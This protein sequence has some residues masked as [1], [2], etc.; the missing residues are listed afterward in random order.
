MT[1]ATL[2]ILIALVAA[3]SVAA[4]A[5]GASKAPSGPATKAEACV[6]GAQVMADQARRGAT[7]FDG[8]GAFPSDYFQTAARAEEWHLSETH[9]AFLAKRTAEN[10][11]VS[12]PELAGRL[13]N[14]TRMATPADLASVR[15]IVPR[16]RIY[17]GQILTPVIAPDGRTALVFESISCSGL[18]GSGSIY[19]YQHVDGAWVRGEAILL[20]FS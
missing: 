17:I 14:G 16:N 15:E 5:I 19:P 4:P 9:Q 6:L 10:L 8:L 18:C 2:R 13:P 7:V 11:F 3:A 12:C 20:V 1:S